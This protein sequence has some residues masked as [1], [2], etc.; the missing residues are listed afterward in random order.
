MNTNQYLILILTSKAH[1]TQHLK[2][3]PNN[4]IEDSPK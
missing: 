2:K 4:K 1:K 3:L